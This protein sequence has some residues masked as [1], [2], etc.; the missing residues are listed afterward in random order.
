MWFQTRGGDG[1]P[2]LRE[3]HVKGLAAER[4]RTHEVLYR[5]LAQLEKEGAIK[6]TPTTILLVPGK[7]I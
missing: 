1:S 3:G 2:I 5:T 7:A 6:R 4:G